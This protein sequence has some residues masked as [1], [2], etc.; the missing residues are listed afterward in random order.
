MATIR[1]IAAKAGVSASTVSRILNND[2]EM[3][4]TEETRERVLNVAEELHYEKTIRVERQV[5]SS[6]TVTGK[7]DA[8][9]TFTIGILQWFS[10]EQE[11]Q[12]DYYLKI[13][14]GIE[15]YCGEAGIG[16]VRS[17]R[18]DENY[19]S[20]LKDVDGLIC[21]GK[22]ARDE[23]NTILYRFHSVIFLDMQVDYP[24]VT[25]L[26][27]DF[28][29]AGRDALHYLESL[30]HQRIA[31]L[32]GRE[33][34]SGKEPIEDIRKKT[35]IE[36]M[37]EKGREYESLIKE[38]AFTTASGY[39]M[40]K[41]LLDECDE[42]PDA[43]F[44]ASDAIAIGAMRAIKEQNYSVPES[45]SVIGINDSEMSAYTAPALTTVA[46]PA[47]DMGQHGA[48]LIYAM[49][50]YRIKTPMKILLPCHLVIRE[51]CKER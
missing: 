11:M 50:H 10:A 1:D 21:V 12:D 16:I 5:K 30:G 35:F 17:Y 34:A 19:I 9:E 45:I 22:F 42:I 6:K 24:E 7:E 36:H 8:V 39:E 29:K 43:V 2:R 40:M 18:S 37:K 20:L 44:A 15:D 3:H 26:N 31:F 48:N 47:Y 28:K 4:V 27:V 51:S 13:R 32:C 33:F 41:E 46:A 14:R 25:T 49:A 38:G 23:V